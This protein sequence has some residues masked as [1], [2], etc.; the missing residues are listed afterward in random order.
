MKKEPCKDCPLNGRKFINQAIDNAITAAW[1]DPTEP[2]SQRA[3][4]RRLPQHLQSEKHRKQIG[5]RIKVLQGK[6]VIGPL[7]Q[8]KGL[9]GRTRNL[10]GLYGKNNNRTPNDAY[11]TPPHAIASLLAR[12]AFHGITWECAQGDGRIVAALKDAGCEAFGTD[13]EK[14]ENFLTTERT[15]ANIVTNPPWKLKTEFIEKALSIAADKVAM[16]LPLSGLTSIE[17]IE[18]FHN[19]EFPLKCIYVFPR[20][21]QFD[22]NRTDNGNGM[23]YCAWFV[24]DRNHVGKPTIE[25]VAKEEESN[26]FPPLAK[27]PLHLRQR[28]ANIPDRITNVVQG[29]NSELIATVA[30][31]HFKREGLR[32][33]DVTYGEGGFWRKL[34][35]TKHK[36]L[37]SDIERW[38]DV[39]GVAQHDFRKLPYESDSLDVVAFDPPFAR[40]TSPWFD[41]RYGTAKF[42]LHQ[43]AVQ[44]LYREGMTEAFRALKV[45][46][47]LLVKC[48]DC[49]EGSRN[50]RTSHK[51]LEYGEALGLED[52]DKFIL[53][54]PSKRL[55]DPRATEQHHAYKA[56]SYLWVLRKR[57]PRKP[58]ILG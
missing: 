51:V 53:L 35:L 9:D 50:W 38:K 33:A 16:L 1:N 43:P 45:G 42:N 27:R 40:H 37:P 39:E 54:F 11:Y 32:I 22:E 15:A 36:F 2:N 8:T 17:R 34:D 21:V 19:A 6:K 18:H 52:V 5:R 56:E 48:Q 20:A 25:W 10:A 47:L 13:I 57:K 29:D 3:I 30:A 4:L 46:G 41:K 24:W 49:R 31:L 28:A 7:S 55:G 44:E 23:L 26:P 58:K 14:G 12:E